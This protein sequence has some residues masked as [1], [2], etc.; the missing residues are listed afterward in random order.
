MKRPSAYRWQEIAQM[1][2]RETMRNVTLLE[3]KHDFADGFNS[4][5]EGAVSFAWGLMMVITRALVWPFTPIL[6]PI[7]VYRTWRYLQKIYAK[8]GES[9]GKPYGT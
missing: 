5:K 6:K 3:W 7:F 8:E 4:L 1:S 9:R 2:F